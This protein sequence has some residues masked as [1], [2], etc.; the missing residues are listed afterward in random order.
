MSFNANDQEEDNTI[1]LLSLW[2][3]GSQSSPASSPCSSSTSTFVASNWLR[4]SSKP[5]Y[6]FSHS[7]NQVDDDSSVTI[8]LSIAPPNARPRAS[9]STVATTASGLNLVPSR[10]WI[11]SPAEILVGATQFSCTVCKKTFNRFNKMQVDERH[12]H[13]WGHGSQ[14][15]R[16]SESLRGITRQL[17]SPSLLKL[18]CYC[19]A[20]GCKNNIEHPRS[21]PLKGFRTLQTH[22]KRKHGVRPFACRRCGKAFA[23]RGDWRTHE[24]NCGKLWF[25][26]CGSDFK[27]KRSLKDHVRSFGSGHAPHVAEPMSI[28][29]EVGELEVKDSD[30]LGG[31]LSISLP[32]LT[33]MYC[34][35]VLCLKGERTATYVDNGDGVTVLDFLAAGTNHSHLSPASCCA[36]PV[37]RLPPTACPL[38]CGENYTSRLLPSPHI[39]LSDYYD[40]GPH[41]RSSVESHPTNNSLCRSQSLLVGPPSLRTSPAAVTTNAHC[42]S[43]VYVQSLALRPPPPAIHSI[44][45]LDWSRSH[46]SPPYLHQ[47]PPYDP[48]AF[49]AML[50]TSLVTTSSTSMAITG[51]CSIE[52]LISQ[53]SGRPP[54]LL[55]LRSLLLFLQWSIPLSVVLSTTYSACFPPHAVHQPLSWAPLPHRE[56]TRKTFLPYVAAP[57]PVP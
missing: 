4:A 54:L 47:N 11:P 48:S 6:H 57:S 21:R 29:E 34:H 39:F 24:K 31:F 17:P 18:P 30:E 42:N 38:L 23:V 7:S 2:P 49:G 22:Y 20:D 14:F 43:L 41:I 50:L 36:C 5:Q 37:P 13:M 3:P 12:M 16:G 35:Y 51:P 28:D 27:H 53:S 8:E 55:F 26:I 9:T 46:Q 33:V 56:R 10:F 25:C 45:K 32:F 52:R 44:A 15:R 19:C 1:L 40:R